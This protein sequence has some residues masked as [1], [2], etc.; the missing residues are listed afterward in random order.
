[1]AKEHIITPE[2]LR[3]L[4][5]YDPETGKLHSRRTGREVFTN[6]HHSGYKK[7][8]V[9]SNTYTAHRVCMAIYLGAWP[10]GEVDHINGDRADNRLANLRVVTKSQNQRNAKKR[11]DNTAGHVGLTLRPNGKWQAYISH[12]GKRQH[13]G[14][15]SSKSDAINARIKQQNLHSYTERHGN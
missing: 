5:R 15:F 12:S 14:T 11:K 4:L 6:T 2:D 8:A 13:I 1:M 7:G 9:K 3:K 10:D